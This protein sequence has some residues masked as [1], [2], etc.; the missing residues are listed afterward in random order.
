MKKNLIVS[1][2]I[3]AGVCIYFT[4]LEAQL[5]KL[6]LA[7]SSATQ[8]QTMDFYPTSEEKVLDN[9]ELVGRI[10]DA[11]FFSTYTKDDELPVAIKIQVQKMMDGIENQVKNY[12]ETSKMLINAKNTSIPNNPKQNQ[13]ILDLEEKIRQYG[14]YFN[15]IINTSKTIGTSIRNYQTDETQRYLYLLN[16]TGDITG[17]Y[18]FVPKKLAL[19]QIQSLA[20]GKTVKIDNKVV[21]ADG[22]N[23]KILKTYLNQ[24]TTPLNNRF[25]F[26]ESKL[27]D[28]GSCFSP[29]KVTATYK[30]N[31]LD[32]SDKP[33]FVNINVSED[34]EWFL[35]LNF[36]SIRKILAA[37]VIFS[38]DYK[39]EGANI[40]QV[41]KN[42]DSN[43]IIDFFEKALTSEKILQ[44]PD[45]KKMVEES[46]EVLGKY[47]A[48]IYPPAQGNTPQQNM[49]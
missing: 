17:Q 39:Y 3:M 37:F 47:I 32:N 23:Q 22:E 35:S 40:I 21:N 33:I 46:Y 19:D 10:L 4:K 6:S 25:S 24:G 13:E 48:I 42:T 1:T 30:I 11:N 27:K 2:F 29:H 15:D 14:V 7:P 41:F 38:P 8:N 26:V 12:A 36:S 31:P 16:P 28:S 9:A 45:L 34:E 43:K 5:Q 18:N 49:Q 44:Q 20:D